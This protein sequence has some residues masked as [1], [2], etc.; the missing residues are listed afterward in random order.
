[1]SGGQASLLELN[2]NRHTA[3]LDPIQY[4]DA[5]EPNEPEETSPSRQTQENIMFLIKQIL[6]HYIELEKSCESNPT[7]YYTHT[8]WDSHL[9]EF[10][11][12]SNSNK[13]VFESK[14][15]KKFIPGIM[16]IFQSIYDNNFW[17]FEDTE[18]VEDCVYGDLDPSDP[19]YP[20]ETF[21]STL[22]EYTTANS[23]SKW[24]EVL[25]KF[26]SNEANDNE[27]NDESN[28]YI[29]SNKIW[30][31]IPVINSD[32]QPSTL[33]V[34]SASGKKRRQKVYTL[35]KILKLLDN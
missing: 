15:D 2:S 18:W 14:L 3:Q 16:G 35:E 27:D 9:T 17:K 7:L 11:G 19:E 24:L 10:E 22:I 30:N 6:T 13:I 23:L 12:L 31:Y 1:V 26:N 5:N 32:L 21:I 33:N 28:Q 8:E 29:G 34:P 20:S 25:D 4:D